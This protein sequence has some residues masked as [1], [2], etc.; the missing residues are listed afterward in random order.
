MTELE[1]AHGL[2]TEGLA[3]RTE[4]AL[5]AGLSAL[6]GALLGHSACVAFLIE[7]VEVSRRARASGFQSVF[8]PSAQLRR[9]TLSSTRA[10]LVLAKCPSTPAT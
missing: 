2:K 10:T 5:V 3:P 8:N 7:H 1:A 9:P 6:V 4:L